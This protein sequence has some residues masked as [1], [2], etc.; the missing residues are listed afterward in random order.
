MDEQ[1]AR[2][3]FTRR[4]KNAVIACS[5]AEVQRNRTDAV[6]VGGV[7]GRHDQIALLTGVP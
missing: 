4:R 6:R 2:D 3:E 5:L 1:R 7:Y